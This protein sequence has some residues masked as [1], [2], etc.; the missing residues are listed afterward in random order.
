MSDSKKSLEI[1]MI[2]A[3]EN[4]DIQSEI[5]KVDGA[6]ISEINFFCDNHGKGFFNRIGYVKSA[7]KIF[8][9][10]DCED[11]RQR[12]YWDKVRSP[13]IYVRGYLYDNDD[14]PNAKAAAAIIRNIHR[15]DI[16]MKVK[17]SVEGGVIARGIED[18]SVLARTKVLGVALT[19]TPANT[20][21]L[22]EPL[23][24]D[25][26]AFNY[27]KD[28][29][30]IN[31]MISLVKTDVPSFRQITRTV[32]AAHILDNLEKA[33]AL[34][35]ANNIDIQFPDVTEKDLIQEALVDRI[36]EKVAKINSLVKGRSYEKK[37]TKNLSEIRD[38][39]KALTAG[40]GGAAAPADRAGGSI[41]QTE[42]VEY[43]RPGFKYIVCDDCGHEGIAMKNQ[44]KCRKCNKSFSMEKLAPFIK[45]WK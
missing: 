39:L 5:L 7:K 12:Y 16:P 29:I 20:A 31:S 17:A 25:K 32:S 43:V 6:D 3:T 40:Y 41:L 18:P 36:S 37:I 33:K 2:A 4:R 26:S 42:A 28:K 19:F 10:E 34:A 24:L 30:L 11:D 27:E 14:H 9:A 1:D 23:N 38:I 22:V 45:D 21:T 15:S 8:K 35:K 44:T 13:Y